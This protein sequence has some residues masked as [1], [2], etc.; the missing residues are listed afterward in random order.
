M[1]SLID[2]LRGRTTQADA[3][4]VGLIRMGG[5]EWSARW[6]FTRTLDSV[7]ANPTAKRCIERNAADFQRPGWQIREKGTDTNIAPGD[8]PEAYRVLN[9]PRP[10]KLSGTAM[11]Y[12]ISR[13][14]DLSG[15]T[16]LL[17]VRGDGDVVD[18]V[19][20]V[21][22]L[23]HMASHRMTV[24]ADADDDLIGFVY[25][26]RAGQVVLLLPEEVV[27]IHYPH[28]D[29]ITD[30]MAP[31]IVAGLAAETDSAA[32]RFNFELLT[33]DSA[34]P[35]YLVI[36]GLNTTQF[37]GWKAEWD[38][39]DS[40]GK[41]RFLNGNG[42]KYVKIGQTN[43]ELTYK[44]LR[45]ASQEDICRALGPPR[46]LIDPTDATF[47]NLDNANRGHL[48]SFVS[49]RWTLVSDEFTLQLGDD[50]GGFDIGFNLDQI[51]ELQEGLDRLVARSVPLLDRDVMTPNEVRR[52]LN[53][54]PVAWGDV[55]L[56]E[57]HHSL[58]MA[59]AATQAELNA[60]S[61]PEAGLEEVT[62]GGVILDAKASIT[63]GSVPPEPAPGFDRA[64]SRHED[65]SEKA[66]ARF[67]QRQ[68]NAIAAKVRSRKSVT[69]AAEV[70]DWFDGDR[71]DAELAELWTPLLGDATDS[72]GGVMLSVF[73]PA[74]EF[75]PNT[76][77]MSRYLAARSVNIANLVNGT[78]ADEIR[79]ILAVTAQDGGAVD[80]MV[81][82]IEGYF[83]PETG[84]VRSRA[85][86]VAR[87]EIIGASNFAA[88]E[89]AR[90]SGVVGGKRWMSAS[91]AEEDCLELNGTLVEDLDGGF[92]HG[93]VT[94]EHPPLHPRCR[95]TLTFD[96]LED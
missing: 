29:R 2:R 52:D 87:T 67:F 94:V 39:A 46:V 69:K 85:E 90:Q 13:D 37:K 60:A 74:Q 56:T 70:A 93:D 42:A 18:D 8:L 38:A 22:G 10:G 50:L 79:D 80:D 77:K 72:V 28:P 89:A 96:I 26:N 54:E 5:S 82:A 32:M 86:T 19:G 17:K 92:S 6:S 24:V 59:V 48:K 64:V 49:P 44:D 16:F 12:L 43:Q 68:G 35:G 66:M 33:N 73:D 7:Y 20:P 61:S 53:L 76:D 9:Q 83:D 63:K 47:A 71:W 95:C 81:D 65:R 25:V 27:Y 88:V 78:T 58:N 84:R 75:D 40:P 36:D 1:P 57:Y 30:R 23:R 11:Q 34:L 62:R 91:D 3:D 15:G 41:T 14:L 31:A 55:S 45:N 4:T 21:T 51:E